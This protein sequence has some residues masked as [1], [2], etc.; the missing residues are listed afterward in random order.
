MSTIF[1]KASR[2]K[3][4][5]ETSRG[6]ISA[7]DLW[8]LPLTSNTGKVNLDDI[9][10]GLH[11]QLKNDSNVSFVHLDRKSDETI[12]LRFDIVKHVIDSRLEENKAN[13][14]ARDNAAKKQKLLEIL[15]EKQDGDLK[16]K[17]ADEL[18]KL[19]AELG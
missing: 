2:L 5:F 1:E 14:Q 15:A 18:Q 19:I 7:E 12:Q 10:R 16:N 4:R 11:S 17:S 13:L 8:D 6:L 9:A 3:L